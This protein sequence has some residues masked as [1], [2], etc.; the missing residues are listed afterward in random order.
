M[1]TK[2]DNIRDTTCG[3]LFQQVF[4][5]ATRQSSNNLAI[6]SW[7]HLCASA[8][9]IWLGACPAAMF[10]PTDQEGEF[11]ARINYV[12]QVY[13]LDLMKVDN[14]YWLFRRQYYQTV[15]EMEMAEKNSPIY[16]GLRGLLCGVPVDELDLAFHER[17]GKQ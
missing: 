10:R 3:P 2:K 16:H 1:T 13:S 9:K 14:E 6:F 11:A 15:K 17:Y 12:A 4:E 7:G 8:E 5:E